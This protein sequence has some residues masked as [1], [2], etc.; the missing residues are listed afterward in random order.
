MIRT[1]FIFLLISCSVLPVEAESASTVLITPAAADAANK[2][3]KFLVGRQLQDG[4][5]GTKGYSRDV[6][7]CG[8]SGMAFLA[9]GSTP[10][11]GPHAESISR[12]IDYLLSQTSDAGFITAPDANSR[13]MYGH[14]FATLFLCEV[15]GMSRQPDLRDRLGLAVELIVGAQND[16]GGWRYQPQPKD[17][18]V[19]VTVCQVMALRAA[20]NAGIAVPRETID[21][22]VAYVQGCQNEDGGFRYMLSQGEQQSQFARSAAGVVALYNGGIYQGAELER[23]LD[24]LAQFRASLKKTASG[25]FYFYAHYYAA[26]AM[27]HAGGERWQQWY[28]AIRDQLI[29]RQRADGSW[30][31]SICAE[32]GTA[33]A[34]IVLQVPNNYLPILQR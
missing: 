23:G 5:F 28:P 33:M 10:T 32:Y 12:C 3:L 9:S 34:C 7:V 17:A 24:Y 21:R 14:G 8:L 15:Y 29:T 2:G 18:D 4:S 11:R 25:G 30:I 31:D 27:W 6:A 16:E 20:R 26:Q 22:A 13:P 1:Y 19:S